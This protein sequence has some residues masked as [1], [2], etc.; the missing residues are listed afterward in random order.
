[1]EQAEGAPDSIAMS[2]STI[3]SVV[4]LIISAIEGNSLLDL[5]SL[6]GRNPALLHQH[7]NGTHPLYV[8]TLRGHIEIVDYFLF[9]GAD[10]NFQKSNGA[11]ALHAACEIGNL[12]LVE[13]LV[14]GGARTDLQRD[15]G[16]TPT[17]IASNRNHQTIV[18]F[19]LGM[20]PSAP[21]NSQYPQPPP[22]QPEL[23]RTVDWN[24]PNPLQ[25]L[26][27]SH[28]WRDPYLGQVSQNTVKI[29]R[30]IGKGAFA[31]VYKC[32]LPNKGCYALKEIG[33]GQDK[34]SKEEMFL[35]ELN[36]LMG[37]NHPVGINNVL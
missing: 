26:S 18:A 10:P 32:F 24:Y 11:T 25:A 7:H 35:K 17:A 29:G 8:A 20:R 23:Q 28:S 34:K 21:T 5:Q 13:R 30:R 12:T 2:N 19:L 3:G 15:D 1:M 14:L 36:N 37:L 4:D 16:M 6:V 27:I 33:L 31:E 9:I 22:S